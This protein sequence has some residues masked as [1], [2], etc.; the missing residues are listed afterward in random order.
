MSAPGG[1]GL[2]TAGRGLVSG[3]GVCKPCGDVSPQ[4]LLYLGWR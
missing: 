3:G 1:V 4:G 2:S